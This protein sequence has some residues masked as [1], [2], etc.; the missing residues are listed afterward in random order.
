MASLSSTSASLSPKPFLSLP[1]PLQLRRSPSPDLLSAAEPSHHCLAVVHLRLQFRCQSLCRSQSL[2][3]GVIP[4]SFCLCPRA[5][6]HAAHQPRRHHRAQPRTV[7]DATSRQP[8]SFLSL[9]LP[10]QLR[11][12]PS[13]DLLSAAE[14]SHH[15][16]AAVHL[17]L[18]FRRQSLCR[19]QSLLPGVIP[20]SF[21]LCPR[22]H[23]HA[24]HQ[25]RRHHRAQPRTVA[26]TH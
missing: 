14:P 18:Q 3:P 17:R 19:S 4:N 7:A 1:L 21:C 24:A 10:L 5:H 26:T 11:R 16:L 13:P 6:C 9:P 25:P 8:I 12:S 15:C 20:N 2:L 23:C 22:A